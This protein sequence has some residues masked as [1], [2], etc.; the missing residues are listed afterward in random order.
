VRG[1]G[2]ARRQT[3]PDGRAATQLIPS[4]ARY[5]APA[6]G[7]LVLVYAVSRDSA[8]RLLMIALMALTLT[9]PAVALLPIDRQAAVEAPQA[10]P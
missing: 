8:A 10:P 6:A 7:I 3:N 1:P 9:N 5:S 2:R 4:H